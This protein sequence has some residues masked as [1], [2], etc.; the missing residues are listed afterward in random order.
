MYERIRQMSIL[1]F[2]NVLEGDC[3]FM[4]HNS[5][6][7]TMIDVNNASKVTTQY[8]STNAIFE[9]F[10]LPKGN[11][12][13]KK[14]PVNPIDY[15]NKFSINN[16]F[17]FV[18]THPDMDHM[19]GIKELFENKTITNF[20][21]TENNK[22]MG[23]FNDSPYN[24]DDWIFYQSLRKGNENIKTLNVYNG[25]KNIYFNQ[26]KDGSEG[27]D[28]ISILC[29]NKKLVEES[30]S[31]ESSDY[32][33]CSYVLLVKSDNKKIIFGG[34]SSDKSWEYILD[35][36]S[37]LVENVDILIAPHHGRKSERN[38][39]FLDIL[40]PRITFFG[41][42]NSEHLAYDAWNKRNLLHIQNNQANCIIADIGPS[43]ILFYVTNET[44]A[45]DFS[46]NNG[47]NT[48][49]SDKLDAWF[50]GQLN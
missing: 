13:Q 38:Y 41:N 12:N 1:H 15:L 37:D 22:D 30:N 33:D 17:R 3:S 18:L 29:P 31:N 9:S 6:N 44:F 24:E 43:A 16:I 36:Y 23:N 19:G 35:N 50:I 27:G 21:D 28:E 39:D 4:Q 34:D 47:Y 48:Y 20:W 5:G 8:K 7:I 26:N 11:Y 42:A 25:S 46:R 10:S 40:K 32:N 45:Q 49:Y 2:L 14:Y